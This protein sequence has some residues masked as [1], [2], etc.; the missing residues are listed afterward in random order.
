MHATQ[1]IS[2]N[3]LTLI[4]LG[5]LLITVG[6]K[7][8]IPLEPVAVTLQSFAVLLIGMLYGVKKSLLAVFIYLIALLI[9]LPI[10]MGDLKTNAGYLIGFV[11]AAGLT[12]FLA[13]NGWSRHIFSAMT[14]AL[15]GSILI[16]FSGW[17]VLAHF[18][19]ATTA[20]NEGVKPFLLADALKIILLAFLV[21]GFLRLIEKRSNA[22]KPSEEISS[23]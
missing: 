7:I 19:D 5:S 15:L 13:E 3:H 6:M 21:P 20:F 4:L 2:L 22:Y 10:F 12:G 11:L 23:Q 8:N 18:L 9:G 1:P 14:A 16:L 17:I